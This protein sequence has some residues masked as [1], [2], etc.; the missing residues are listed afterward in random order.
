MVVLHLYVVC[1]VDLHDTKDCIL[2]KL[3]LL[4]FLLGRPTFKSESKTNHVLLFKHLKK[5]REQ[6]SFKHSYSVISLKVVLRWHGFCSLCHMFGLE[7]FL[8]YQL[9]CAITLIY[10]F[11]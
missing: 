2:N 6:S 5:I 4:L 3:Q 11:L 10:I 8:P 7:V 1:Y 9:F